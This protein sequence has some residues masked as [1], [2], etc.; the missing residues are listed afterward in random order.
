VGEN[1]GV[2]GDFTLDGIAEAGC[3][4]AEKVLVT[5]ERDLDFEWVWL[6]YDDT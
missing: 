1:H 6:L 5:S 3:R 4:I 2:V